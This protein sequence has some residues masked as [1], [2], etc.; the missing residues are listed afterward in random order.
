M[1]YNVIY[2]DY[3]LNQT[4]L[5]LKYGNKFDAEHVNDIYNQCG[6][7]RRFVCVTDNKKGLNPNIE[8]IP[9]TWEPEGHWEKVKLF[10][11]N[12][13]GR[14]LYLDLDVVI[15][16]PID[17]LFKM[18]DKNPMIC[19]TYW[20]HPE[21]YKQVSKNWSENYISN[22]NSSVMMWEDAT[23]IY[24]HFVNNK[25]Y[26]MV[27]YAGDDRFLWHEGFKFDYFPKEYI[28]SFAYGADFEIGDYGTLGG[29]PKIREEFNICLLNGSINFNEDLKVLYDKLRMHKVG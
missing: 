18:L 19:Y 15:Q 20:K 25:D 2:K 14:I 24:E 16:K 6:E 27:K 9:I 12:N 1:S 17:N 21:H 8:V 26:F 5:T 11:I 28:Y 13:L 10:K 7:N 4:I 22:H 23:H 29:Y 3:I